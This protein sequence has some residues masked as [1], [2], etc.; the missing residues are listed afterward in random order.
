MISSIAPPLIKCT[1]TSVS[2]IKTIVVT[3]GAKHVAD[4]LY[5]TAGIGTYS[6]DGSS[7]NTSWLGTIQKWISQQ[8][9]SGF[10]TTFD[11]HVIAGYR[12][13][14]RY[15]DKGD[16][17]Y[18]FGFS[19]GAFTARFLAR[20]ISQVGL[21]SKGN[22]EM[23]PFA[24]KTYQDYELGAYQDSILPE[25]KVQRSGEESVPKAHKPSPKSVFIQNF[26]TTFCRHDAHPKGEVH[27]DLES[28]IKVHFLGLFDT[29]NSV[30][31]FDVPFTKQVILPMVG[32]T[33][34]HVRHAVAIDERRVKFKAALL[35]QDRR[36]MP[37]DEDIKEVWFPGNHGDVGGGWPARDPAKEDEVLTLKQKI[38]GFF[39]KEKDTEP[40]RDVTK[41]WFQQS[42]IA[43]K[44]MIDELDGIDGDQIDWDPDRRKVFMECYAERRDAAVKSKLHDTMRYGGGS[45]L[46]KTSFWN[47]M[48][49]LASLHSGAPARRPRLR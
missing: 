11:S 31:T 20:M 45:S 29:V 42:D 32:G 49:T 18:I 41:D 23:V 3:K 1:I 12:F 36:K 39:T 44:W 14:M 25:E 26:K 7:V 16:R 46:G 4:T 28:G 9:D 37:H 40:S 6:G 48:G 21:L 10:G 47:F 2:S 13:L 34:E 30:G 8:I 24:Y 33:A 27:S 38:E 19:R 17:I 22:E 5:T 35:A 15:Y 43:L